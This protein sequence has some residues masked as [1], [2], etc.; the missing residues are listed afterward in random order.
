MPRA[1]LSKKLFSPNENAEK[2]RESGFYAYLIEQS[3]NIK[4]PW[5]TENRIQSSSRQK[6]LRN[7]LMSFAVLLFQNF[8]G[9]GAAKTADSNRPGAYEWIFNNSLP[10]SLA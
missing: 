4:T 9:E 2:N 1:L 5:I 6:K 10:S 3:Y 7:L 8:C